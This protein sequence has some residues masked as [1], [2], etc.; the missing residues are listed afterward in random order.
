MPRDDEKWFY[1]CH[2]NVF[3]YSLM[4][5]LAAAAM[6]SVTIC[7]EFSFTKLYTDH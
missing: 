4:D 6:E 1:S 5:G 3:L 7:S 2:I